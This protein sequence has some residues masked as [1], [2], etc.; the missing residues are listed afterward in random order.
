[1]D[2][3]DVQHWKGIE[4]RSNSVCFRFFDLDVEQPCGSYVPCSEIVVVGQTAVSTPFVE[5]W[6]VL[7]YLRFVTSS[8]NKAL[9]ISALIL[10]DVTAV[11]LRRL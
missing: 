4:G 7:Q 11:S 1:M 9:S 10:F 3:E 8:R 2:D 6:L 5:R